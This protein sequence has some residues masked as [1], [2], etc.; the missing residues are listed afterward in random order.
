MDVQNVNVQGLSHLYIDEVLRGWGLGWITIG[1][2]PLNNGVEEQ[3]SYLDSPEFHF[4]VDLSGQIYYAIDIFGHSGQKDE[5]MVWMKFI[6]LGTK[7]SPL[8]VYTQPHISKISVSDGHLCQMPRR[9]RCY[10]KE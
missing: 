9:P 10:H 6:V 2:P 8:A 7:F 1:T 5:D 3:G 4:G